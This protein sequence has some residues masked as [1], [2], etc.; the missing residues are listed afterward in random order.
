M[1]VKLKDDITVDV[2]NK[3]TFENVEL[4]STDFDAFK[5]DEL[6]MQEFDG[7]IIVEAIKYGIDYEYN[8]AGFATLFDII[9]E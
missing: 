4:D 5:Y 2:F 1:E 6:E 9:K 3:I 7:R 8:Y